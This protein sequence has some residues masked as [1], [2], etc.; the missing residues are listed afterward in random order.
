MQ[1]HLV[2]L[3]EASAVGFSGS[4][5]IHGGHGVRHTTHHE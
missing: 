1:F 5:D 4:G 2:G 3:V